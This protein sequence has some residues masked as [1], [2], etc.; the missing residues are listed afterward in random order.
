[1]HFWKWDFQKYEIYFTVDSCLCCFS[2]FPLIKWC[3]WI[4]MPQRPQQGCVCHTMTAF[5]LEKNQIW[6]FFFFFKAFLS[7]FFNSL[8]SH[9]FR[10][11]LRTLRST[12]SLSWDAGN[13]ICHHKGGFFFSCLYF[14]LPQFRV[15]LC[16]VLSWRLNGIGRCL[17]LQTV[18]SQ[19]INSSEKRFLKVPLKSNKCNL[20]PL[21][22]VWSHLLVCW[23]CRTSCQVLKLW[24][25]LVAIWALHE[26]FPV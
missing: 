11:H 17:H 18:K 6:T 7:S 20:L 23:P 19:I 3:L 16:V 10:P 5:V 13:C 15:V 9:A 4:L 21:R 22:A 1:M 24:C 8:L 2:L 14:F 12:V 26:V 25:C